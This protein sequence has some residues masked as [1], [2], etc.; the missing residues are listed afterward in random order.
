M[1]NPQVTVSIPTRNSASTLRLCL[2]SIR[3]QTYKNIEINIVDGGSTDK[4]REVARKFRVD[5]FVLQKEGSLLAARYEGVKIAK[6]KFILI[7]DSDQILEKTVIERAVNMLKNNRLDMLV[8]EEDVYKSE[9]FVEKLFQMD[10]QLINKISDLSPFTGVAMPRFFRAALLKEAY[11]KIPK[12]VFLRTGGPDHAIVY[13]ESWKISKK[14]GVLPHAVKHMEPSTFGQLWRK[15]YRW[16]YTSVIDSKFGKYKQLMAQ[17]ER[18]RTGIF[19]KG[20]IKESI[21]SIFLVGMKYVPFKLGYFIA[22]ID[23]NED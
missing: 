10:R 23:R 20:L 11:R 21:G 16:G 5:K 15:F 1:K 6:G 17:K 2:R 9:T 19:S 8:L 4:T 3:S 18:L 12:S 13:Y 14:V 7:F 22:K